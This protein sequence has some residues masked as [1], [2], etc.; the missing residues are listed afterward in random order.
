MNND[1]DLVTKAQLLKIRRAKKKRRKTESVAVTSSGEEAKHDLMALLPVELLAEILSYVTP[2]E[3]LAIARCSR[4]L[5]ETLINPRLTYIWR[6]ARRNCPGAALCD[7]TPNFIGQAYAAFGFDGGV[8][9]VCRSFLGWTRF[10]V[11]C[12]VSCNRRAER[13]SIGC[14]DRSVFV[15]VCVRM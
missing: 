11:S 8:R 13:R 2:R 6:Y 12:C 5:C 4:H 1:Q 14:T 3:V 10:T 7:P 15:C 9:E